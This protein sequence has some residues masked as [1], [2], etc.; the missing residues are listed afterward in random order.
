MKKIVISIFQILRLVHYINGYGRLM[1]PIARNY[2]WRI[3]SS[4]PR[5]EKDYEMHCG[6]FTVSYTFKFKIHIF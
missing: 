2:L 4:Y 6:G 3:D 5:N 1:D